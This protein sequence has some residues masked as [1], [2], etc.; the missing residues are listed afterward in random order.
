MK[1]RVQ[2]NGHEGR[3]WNEIK[4]GGNVTKLMQFFL[5]EHNK[6]VQYYIFTYSR[7]KRKSV[8]EMSQKLTI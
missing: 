3:K 8:F 4:S 2:T 5:C 6:F 7:N 1:Y